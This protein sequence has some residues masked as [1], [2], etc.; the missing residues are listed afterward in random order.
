[1][2]KRIFTF[3]VERWV[4]AVYENVVARL[5]NVCR[6]HGFEDLDDRLGSMVRQR[7][8]K[9]L[10]FHVA[11]LTYPPIS[12]LLPGCFETRTAARIRSI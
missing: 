4:N 9:T 11:Q 8:K 12:S 10:P 5:F 6:A 2:A 3:R 7:I 1:M